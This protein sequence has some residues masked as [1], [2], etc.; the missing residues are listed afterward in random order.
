MCGVAKLLPV[1][2]MRGAARPGDLDVDA[3]GEE[4]DRR[5]GVVVEGRRVGLLVAADGDDR[6]EAPRVALDRHV[7]GRRDEHRALEVRAVGELVEDPRELALRRREAHVDDVEAL[8]DRPAQPGQEDAAAPGEAGARARG[9]S[10]SSQ[11]GA[12]DADDPRAGRPVAAEVALG[13]VLDHASP[14]GSS[15]TATDRWTSPDERMVR[16]RRRCRGCRRARPCR[17]SRPTPTRAS[18]RR[19]TRPGA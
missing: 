19:A 1:Q 18:P 5:I 9:R 8:L 13:V 14:S 2:R 15:E 16:L 6:G 12:S 7:V 17:S 11:S 4:L 10:S 3:A